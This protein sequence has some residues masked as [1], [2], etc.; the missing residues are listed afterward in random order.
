MTVQLSHP[1]HLQFREHGQLH[2]G[3]DQDWFRSFWQRKAGCGPTTGAHIV[4]YL[5]RTGRLALAGAMEGRDD[6]VDLMEHSWGFLTPTMMGLNSTQLMRDGLGAF[7]DS[8]GSRPSVRVMDVPA[9][10]KDR[11]SPEAAEEFIR[12]GLAQDSPVAF[13]NLHNGGI[14]Q[15]ET[16]HW[17]TVVGIRDSNQE[18]VLDIY[19]NGSRISVP[20]AYWLRNTRR[21]G[22][23]VFIQKEADSPGN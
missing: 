12:E 16:W 4:L 19:D 14:P 22:G 18:T 15:L 1:E 13:L 3:A 10:E 23:F 21:G 11:P 2:Y 8:L 7:L 20:L 17:V 6:F 9:E 5:A